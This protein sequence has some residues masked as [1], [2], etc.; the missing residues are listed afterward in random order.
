MMC[1]GYGIQVSISRRSP[2]HMSRFSGA[3]SAAGGLSPAR[4]YRWR[5]SALLSRSTRAT[6]SSTC[7]DTEMSRPC[8]SHW[9][10]EAPTPAS[11]A[12]SSRRS[13]GVRRRPRRP[14]DRRRRA[15]AW[16]G[17]SSGTP[18]ARP[19][20]R[21]CRPPRPPSCPARVP[22]LHPVR[23]QPGRPPCLVAPPP[24]QLAA[25]TAIPAP[26]GSCPW[27][28]TPPP[29]SVN[30]P[31]RGSRPRQAGPL[32]ALRGPVHGRAGLLRPERRPAGPRRRPGHE[33]LRPAVGGDRVR[34]AVRRLP[35]ALRPDRRPLRPPPAVPGRTRPVRRRLRA[36]D[37][38][39]GPGVVPRRARPAGRRCRGRRTD[40]HVA[41]DHDLP[42]GPP[43][44]APSA[45][46]ARCCPSVSRSAWW[47]AAS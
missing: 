32:R 26:A 21:P 42:E 1:A 5:R 30:R 45:S 33:H 39:V 38:R 43:A 40:R 2:S 20:V 7:G 47:P 13:P 37:V 35:A 10:Q 11:T 17:G 4:T 31:R 14:A 29:P 46:P 6:A 19:G 16:P 8:S 18:A 22:R 36:R 23:S 25:P 44:T 9:Y 28:S 34:A 12:T 3:T 15:R 27:R 24:G 41:A